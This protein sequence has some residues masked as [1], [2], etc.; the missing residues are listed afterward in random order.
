MTSSD[1]P[2]VDFSILNI[3]NVRSSEA[4]LLREMDKLKPLGED[5]IGALEEFGFCYLKNP[6]LSFEKVKHWYITCEVA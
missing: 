4:Q 1:L 6:G 5:L 2:I 3:A